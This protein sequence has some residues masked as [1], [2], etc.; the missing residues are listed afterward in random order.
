MIRSSSPL[1]S[2][3]TG[4]E[5]N[6]KAQTISILDWHLGHWMRLPWKLGLN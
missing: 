6:A 1:A 4:G 5:H 3:V 2:V